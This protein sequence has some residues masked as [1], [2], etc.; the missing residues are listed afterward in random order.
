MPV[1]VEIRPAFD[2]RSLPTEEWPC[3]SQMQNALKIKENYSRISAFLKRKESSPTE[4]LSPTL[5][6]TGPHMVAL[7][8]CNVL[9]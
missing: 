8:P 4:G 9:A 2:H 1:K 5:E 6:P 3:L 7:F